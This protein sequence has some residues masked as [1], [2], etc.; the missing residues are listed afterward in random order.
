[1]DI[2]RGLRGLGALG[3]LGWLG[4]ALGL[5][6]PAAGPAGAAAPP[7]PPAVTGG[8]APALTFT[9]TPAPPYTLLTEDFESGTLGAFLGS[10][11]ISTTAYSGLY[12][13]RTEFFWS[14]PTGPAHMTVALPLVWCNDR[15]W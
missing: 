8:H 10:F 5:T 2:R 14:D 15:H 13:A 6:A 1:M 4:V 12:A 3:A 9:P 7:A 11:G